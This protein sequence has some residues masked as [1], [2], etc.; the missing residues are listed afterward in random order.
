MPP[1][2][3]R[4]LV[5]E[6]GPAIPP[7][8]FDKKSYNLNPEKYLSVVEPGR[9][10]QTAQPSA[11]TAKLT[12]LSR[13]YVQIQQGETVPL[14][15][16][17]LP[18]MPV[19]FTSFDL[20]QFENQLTS[21]TVKADRY[22]I[23]TVKFTGTTGTINDVSILAAS[24]STSGQARFVVTVKLPKPAGSQQVLM[25]RTSSSV[26]TLAA[27]LLKGSRKIV[28]GLES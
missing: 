24:P 21:I 26:E 25:P 5:K 17:A 1:R 14:R 11:T 19:T 22:G 9:V 2:Q 10:F 12:A 28:A 4:H 15:V 3:T 8:P 13:R 20:G 23:A 27:L 16:R 18:G 6:G 7:T